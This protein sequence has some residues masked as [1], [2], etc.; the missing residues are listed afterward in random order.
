M[1]Q[2][3]VHK[4]LRPL[5]KLIEDGKIDPSFVITHRLSLTD[6][7]NGYATFKNNPNEC[8][9]VVMTTNGSNGASH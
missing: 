9:K 8:I 5:L 4:Y 2:T 7:S 1:G 6:A 3:N